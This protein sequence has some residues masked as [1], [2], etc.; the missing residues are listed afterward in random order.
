MADCQ[1]VSC[2][3]GGLATRSA[4]LALGKTPM[5]VPGITASAGM[6]S[7]C[8]VQKLVDSPKHKAEMFPMVGRPSRCRITAD[9][10]ATGHWSCRF[11]EIGFLA[12]PGSQRVA[13]WP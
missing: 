4:C 7:L 9:K 2:A 3:N 12:I 1:P 11:R 13:P 8:I 6:T 5:L 10:E